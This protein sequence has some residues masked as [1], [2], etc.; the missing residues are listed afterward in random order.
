MVAIFCVQIWDQN[1]GINLKSRL[2]YLLAYR[3]I[4]PVFCIIFGEKVHLHF[5][6]A[7]SSQF[8]LLTEQHT[9]LVFLFHQSR[10]CVVL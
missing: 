1:I 4:T 8:V 2:S 5:S 10:C 9:K 3:D 6:Y 7:F